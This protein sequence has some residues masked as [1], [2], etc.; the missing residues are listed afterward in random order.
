MRAAAH[1]ALHPPLKLLLFIPARM[2]MTMLVMMVGMSGGWRSL[3]G[4]IPIGASRRGQ[5]ALSARVR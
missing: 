4:M 5:P 1:R 3:E 2:Q